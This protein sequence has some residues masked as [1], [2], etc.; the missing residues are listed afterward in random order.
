MRLATIL[1]SLALAAA[2]LFGCGGSASSTTTT[3][4]RAGEPPTSTNPPSTAKI[5]ASWVASPGCKHPRGASRWG[6]SVGSYRCQAVVT[7]RGWSVDC[8]K[9][10]RSL[11]FTVPPRN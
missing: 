1:A 11:A 8:A 5:R 2:V 6:C 9:P 7:D 3:P 4:D 10:G